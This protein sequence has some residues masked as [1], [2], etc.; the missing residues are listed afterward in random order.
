MSQV[1]Q[2]T[3]KVYLKVI[4]V[5]DNRFNKMRVVNKTFI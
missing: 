1:G 4:S 5:H 3:F 2:I